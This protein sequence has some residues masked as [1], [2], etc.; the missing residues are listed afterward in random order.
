[1]DNKDN[2]M[3]IEIKPEIASGS[4]SNLAVITHSRSEFIIDFA[5]ML[6]G[7]PAAQVNNRIVMTPDHVKRLLNALMDNISKYENQFGQI[8]GVEPRG[9]LNLADFAPQGGAKS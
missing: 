5:T 4:Y 8:E 7:V 3:K 9:T 6:P 1:M 2:Q